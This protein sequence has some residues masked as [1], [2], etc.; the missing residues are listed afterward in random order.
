LVLLIRNYRPEPGAL[1]D[2]NPA[3]GTKNG[4]NNDMRRP[5]PT[6]IIIRFLIA[7]L[8]VLLIGFLPLREFLA[9][10]PV[11][12][13][14]AVPSTPSPP[15]THMPTSTKPATA[16]TSPT[17]PYPRIE[18]A[19]PLFIA[20]RADSAVLQI[21]PHTNEIT[22]RVILEG[23]ID[24][25]AADKGSVWIAITT[26][27]YDVSILRLDSQDLSI[28]AS[29]PIYTGWA[30][31][32][33]AGANAVWV[34]IDSSLM[35]GD[36]SGKLLRIDP[37]QNEI[38]AVISRPAVPRTMTAYAQI[39][40]LLEGQDGSGTAARMDTTSRQII[41]LH[42]HSDGPRYSYLHL[43]IGA[44]GAWV[45]AVERE[46]SYLTQL[47]PSSGSVIQ[48]YLLGS[49]RSERPAA[50]LVGDR[51]VWVA[52]Q[53]GRLLQIDPHLQN[54]VWHIQ[55]M[56]GL[57]KIHQ[58]A[59]S[60]WIENRDEAALYRIDP[61]Q[62]ELLAILSSGTKPAPTPQPSPTLP[63]GMEPECDADYGTRLAKGGKA[64]VKL[65]PP[66][67]NRLRSEPDRRAKILGQIEPGEMINLI[68][69]P[70][71]YNGWI[72]WYVQS[73]QSGLRGWTSEGDRDAYWLSPVE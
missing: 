70:V 20:N 2:N 28:Q 44:A 47:D 72:W 66:L 36:G 54:E 26:G 64:M 61:E 56:P 35:D 34:G 8:V 63:P 60:I 29:I 23:S 6:I 55:L 49:T 53:D 43:S 38:N 58:H 69:G 32:L 25:I 12:E 48:T 65:E 5:R 21:D 50:L 15:A 39:L 37:N 22:G 46:N 18:Q 67:P 3:R 62:G 59:G 73:R 24:A 14:S 7:L 10:A 17:T 27:R 31:C 45:T 4:Y 19:E 40:W 16:T 41:E 30:R 57:E 42:D 68:D 9:P 1:Q 11:D 13:I 51:F 71:C 33:E 52:L